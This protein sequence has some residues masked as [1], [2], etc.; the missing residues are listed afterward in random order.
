MQAIEEEIFCKLQERLFFCERLNQVASA[1]AVKLA[2]KDI[3]FHFLGQQVS[4]GVAGLDRLP[5]KC[6]RNIK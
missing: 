3:G 6:G 5:D 4:D 2:V 1:L